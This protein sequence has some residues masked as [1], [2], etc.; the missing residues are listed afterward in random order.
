M[1]AD[2]FSSD[3]LD[4]LRCLYKQEVR[5]LIVGGE[6][7]IYYGHPRLTGDIDFYYERSPINCDRL[8]DALLEFWDQD[9]P[10]ID[11][12]ADLEEPGAIFQFG[13]PPNRID[14]IN[15][16][17]GVSFQQAW[18]SREI[19]RFEYSNISIDVYVIGLDQ[20]IKNKESIKRYKDLEDL[21]YL[22]EVQKNRKK[23]DS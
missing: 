21:K 15:Q 1:N 2:H 9:I 18:D 11:A 13:V 22:R 3:T 7:V 16:I 4:F 23:S 14:L 19:T 20:L 6:A 10:G 12:A 5:N 17:D 8:Y